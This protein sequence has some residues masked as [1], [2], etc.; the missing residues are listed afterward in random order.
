MGGNKQLIIKNMEF[1]TEETIRNTFK[2]YDIVTDKSGNVGFIQEVGIIDTQPDP[3]WQISY[4][5]NWLVGNET[6][7]AWFRHEELTKHCS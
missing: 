1:V 2:P 6:K 5:V 3:Y 7:V 4:C